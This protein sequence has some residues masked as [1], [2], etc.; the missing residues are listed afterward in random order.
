[1]TAPDFRSGLFLSYNT[2]KNFISIFIENCET[3]VSNASAKIG[4]CF[5]FTMPERK[6]SIFFFA[7][8]SLF[9]FS[10]RRILEW[11]CKHR[12][13]DLNTQVFT[14]QKL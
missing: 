1:M 14:T 7:I 12:R 10:R 3:L 4:Y 8:I 6:F 13:V 5:V 9:K 11:E 2:S